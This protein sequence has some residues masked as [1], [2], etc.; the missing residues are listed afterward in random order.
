MGGRSVATAFGPEVDK[1]LEPYLSY[2]GFMT[3]PVLHEHR[4]IT[5][6]LLCKLEVS[7]FVFAKSGLGFLEKGTTI[8]NASYVYPMDVKNEYLTLPL[9]IGAD[10]LKFISR[11]DRLSLSVEGGVAPSTPIYTQGYTPSGPYG[12]SHVR[13]HRVIVA[14]QWGATL[15]LAITERI[16]FVANYSGYRDLNAFYFNPDKASGSPA[17]R[18]M[19]F[20]GYWVTGGIGYALK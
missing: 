11:E 5:F 15:E 4:S 12:E 20:K 1:Q 14:L 3:D 6:S 7:R 16:H 19:F 2:A 9:L 17:G 8:E 10:P 18:A 13:E